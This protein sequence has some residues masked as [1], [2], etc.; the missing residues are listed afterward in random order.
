M[1]RILTTGYGENGV[2]G[3]RNQCVQGIDQE[4]QKMPIEESQGLWLEIGVE[5]E[6]GNSTWKP[7]HNPLS[8]LYFI[9]QVNFIYDKF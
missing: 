2:P 9:L 5:M 7:V 3:F 8:N 4:K 6:R 1:N